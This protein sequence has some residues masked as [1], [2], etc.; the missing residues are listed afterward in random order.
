MDK[1]K[2]P[3]SNRL[4]KVLYSIG[5]LISNQTCQDKNNFCDLFS[6]CE[7]KKELFEELENYLM[8]RGLHTNVI[9]SEK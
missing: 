4:E 5:E 6:S 2:I 8:R 7:L 1:H 3:S 9:L